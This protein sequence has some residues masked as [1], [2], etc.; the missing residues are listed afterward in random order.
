MQTYNINK[1][2]KTRKMG[3][4]ITALVLKGE[5]DIEKAKKY[6][7]IPV[8]LKYDLSL[9]YIDS[10]YSC[11]WQYKMQT[12]GFLETNCKEITWFPSEV[13]IHEL[14]KK[15]TN[16]EDARFAI[17]QTEY[18]GGMGSQYAN[19]Y[20]GRINANLSAKTINQVLR[21]IGVLKENGMDEFDTV[22]LGAYRVNPEYL[23]KYSELTE[24]YDL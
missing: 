20:K 21:E 23:Y 3:H 5:F 15:I 13:V 7:L 8:K 17:I 1:K 14:M 4:A 16:K 11:Y 10:H 6:D 19:V 24:K 9:F 2:I 12:S 18:H 22:G